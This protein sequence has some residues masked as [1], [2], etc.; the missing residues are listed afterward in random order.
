MA[1][2]SQTL[3]HTS[4]KRCKSLSKPVSFDEKEPGTLKISNIAGLDD[5]L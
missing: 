2:D 4:R 5:R 1:V 3:E